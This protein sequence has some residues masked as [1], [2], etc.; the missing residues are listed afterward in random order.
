MDIREQNINIALAANEA[1]QVVLRFDEQTPAETNVTLALADGAHLDVVILQENVASGKRCVVRASQQSNSALSM[2]TITHHS[3][4]IKND[5]EVKLQ[6]EGA[7]LTLNGLYLTDNTE[8]VDN[9]T[10]V[11]H[12][13]GH[14]TTKQLYKGALDGESKASFAGMIIVQPDAQKTSAQQTNRNI[15]VSPKAKVHAEPQLV[16]YADDVKCS[17]GATTGQLDPVQLFYMQQRG[18]NEDAARRMLTAAYA[19]EV[20][21]LIPIEEVRERLTESLFEETI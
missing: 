16:I 11:Y 14:C 9:K 17:H 15:L 19:A 6:G 5:V 13:V 21:A 2:S 8:N 3:S 12:E 7:E 18:I 20:V 10:V 1:K 4:D